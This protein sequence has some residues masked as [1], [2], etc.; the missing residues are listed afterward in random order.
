MNPGHAI[1]TADA[2]RDLRVRT[3]RAAALGDDVMLA[4]AVPPEFRR[5]QDHYPILFR[6]DVERESFAAVALF[7]F[8][9][10]ENLFLED[11]RWDAGYRPL[12]IDV[13]PFLIG[14]RPGGFGAKQVHVDLGSRRIDRTGEG[15]RLFDED[16]RPTPY[17][18]RASE[19][20]GEL[21]AGYGTYDGFFDAL[22]RYELLEP[23]SLDV[24]L[25]DGSTNR[26]VGF[27]AIDE[28]RLR[29]LD[30]EALGDLHLNDHLLPIFMAVA[31]LGRFSALIARK[32]RRV[33]GG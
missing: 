12:A 31:S 24:R 19:L 9:A 32:N 22:A 3:D 5:L 16:G 13:Q 14:G 8:E 7:G 1:L 18:E 15:V 10:G 20:L 29:G 23:L 26:L 27:H 17:L 6:L 25:E 28:E 30:G 2:H 21:D 33:R 11:G 4:L